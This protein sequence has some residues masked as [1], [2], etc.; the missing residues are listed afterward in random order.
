MT[1]SVDNSVMIAPARSKG[2]TPLP[3]MKFKQAETAERG[4]PVLVRIAQNL[5]SVV[6]EIM[7]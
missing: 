1:A 7:T 6:A 3:V 5:S 4:L 2:A